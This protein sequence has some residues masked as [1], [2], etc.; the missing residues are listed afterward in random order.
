MTTRRAFIGA[1]TGGLLAAPLVAEAQQPAA[2][3]YRIGLLGGSPPTAA[4]ASARLWEVLFQEL[5]E[6]GYVEGQNIVFEGRWYGERTERLPALAAELVQLKVDV[7][8]TGASP[9]PEAAQHA[10][11]AIPIVFASHPDPVGSGLA[12]SLAKPGRNV[13]GLS[14]LFRELVGKQLQLLKEAVPRLSRVAV[15]WNPTV[16]T[17][18][19]LLREADVAARSLKV[20][21]QVLEARAPGDFAPAFSAMTKD[22]AGALITLTSPM[23]FAERSRIVELAAKSRLPTIYGAKEYA[24]AGG[25]MAY[26][27]SLRENWRRAATYVDKI[28]KGAKPADLPIEQPTKFEL[29]INLKAA[30]ALGLTIPQS[31]LRRAGEVIQ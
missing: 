17:Q 12:V 11:S 3:V 9:A 8:V 24:E 10:T 29:V 1:L 7:I 25:L 19:V 4:E 14:T 2:K 13:T 28:L 18:A 6:L 26:G 20:Q 31:L 30:K 27:P 15:L 23:F 16:A 5:R 22:R 21:V